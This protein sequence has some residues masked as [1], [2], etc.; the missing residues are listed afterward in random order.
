M[1]KGDSEKVMCNTIHQPRFEFQRYGQ[2]SDS[3]PLGHRVT[4]A[5]DSTV[6]ALIDSFTFPP[7]YPTPLQPRPSPDLTHFSNRLI[8]LYSFLS[9]HFLLF[10]HTTPGIYPWYLRTCTRK[11]KRKEKRPPKIRVRVWR[12]AKK[13]KRNKKK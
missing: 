2:Q 4:R 10:Y 12:R 8:L 3:L 7:E 13:R 11:K 9:A 5:A 1:T 6:G